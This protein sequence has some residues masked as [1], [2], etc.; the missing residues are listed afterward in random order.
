MYGFT[1][2]TYNVLKRMKVG[3]V[4]ELV[5]LTKE[6]ILSTKGAG[7]AVLAEIE[8]RLGEYNLSLATEKK[9]VKT[10][11]IYDMKNKVTLDGVV[12]KATL[13][14]DKGTILFLLKMRV[15]EGKDFYVRCTYFGSDVVEVFDKLEQG[16]RIGVHGILQRRHSHPSSVR[17]LDL[18][19][20]NLEDEHL[21]EIS[22]Y[23][24]EYSQ[25]AYGVKFVLFADAETSI[26]C[27]LRTRKVKETLQ[28]LQKHADNKIPITVKD[29]LMWGTDERY[30]TY[31]STFA[32]SAIKKGSFLT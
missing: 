9:P 12:T 14:E 23:V 11:T 22:G 1:T 27:C 10:V 4:S 24:R 3:Y 28:A 15:E 17:A 5:K 16:A 2:R 20:S 19:D 18:S 25:T 8:D 29:R 30:S 21:V 26:L 7:K 13:L 31:I 6:D 32:S